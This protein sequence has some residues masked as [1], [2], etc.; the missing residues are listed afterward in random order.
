MSLTE[1]GTAWQD[2]STHAS[3]DE[4]PSSV[5]AIICQMMLVTLDYMITFHSEGRPSHVWHGWWEAVLP[6]RYLYVLVVVA[7]LLWDE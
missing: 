6:G 7:Y 4:H 2:V 1:R 5:C 3:Q